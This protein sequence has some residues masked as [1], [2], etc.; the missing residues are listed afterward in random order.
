MWK[1]IILTFNDHKITELPP[2]CCSY[3][4][5]SSPVYL[6]QFLSKTLLFSCK[7][8]TLQRCKVSFREWMLWS[9][10]LVLK[11]GDQLYDSRQGL[12]MTTVA[13]IMIS[14]LINTLCN[15][16]FELLSIRKIINVLLRIAA[17]TISPYCHIAF[18]RNSALDITFWSTNACQYWNGILSITLF[19]ELLFL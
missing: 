2:L 10:S 9:R 17:E 1:L 12:M 4:R 14:G 16:I 15:I 19:S 8:E 13:M 6:S 7:W 18:S 3:S 11:P 5:C